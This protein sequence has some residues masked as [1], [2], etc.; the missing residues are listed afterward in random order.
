[1]EVW[2]KMVKNVSQL[3]KILSYNSCEKL[4]F[5]LRLFKQWMNMQ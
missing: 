4:E 5:D 3:P 1:M 2:Q